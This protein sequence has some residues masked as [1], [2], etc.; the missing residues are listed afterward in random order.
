MNAIRFR[1]PPAWIVEPPVGLEPTRYLLGRQACQ[2]STL[3]R[4]WR[5]ELVAKPPGSPK[6]YQPALSAM[7]A[8]RLWSPYL[9]L[10]A[11]LA[12]LA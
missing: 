4:L 2:P 7:G 5:D 11:V 1:N 3:R 10:R 9:P 6:G 12:I 8:L